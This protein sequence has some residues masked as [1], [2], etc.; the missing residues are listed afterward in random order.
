[1]KIT[2]AVVE[3]ESGPF[4]LTEVALDDPRPDEMIVRMVATGMCHTDLSVRKG[5]TPFPLPAVLGHEGAGVV[6]AVGA[7]VGRF[8]PGDRVIISFASCGVCAGCSSGRPV[9]CGHWT[10]LN[11]LGGSRLDASAPITRPSGPVHGHFFGQSSFASHALVHERSAIKAPDDVDLEVLAPLGCSVQTGVG[12]V[13]NVA[14]PQPGSTLLVF[15]AGGVGLAALM[16]SKLTAAARVIAVDINPSRLELAHELGATHTVNS[17]ETDPFDA[18]LELTGGVGADYAIETTGRPAV[19]ETAIACM[20]SGGTTVVVGAPPLGTTIPV[21]VPNLLGRGIRLVGTNQGD[22]DPSR[23]LPRLIDLHRRGS[24]PFDR[25][26][27]RFPFDRI[28]DA[29]AAAMN[30][31]VIKPV[32]VMPPVSEKGIHP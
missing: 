23:F 30:G 32:L 24:L 17:A 22:S 12:A 10:E 1:M 28:N 5:Q 31:T 27:H 14:R 20:A 6:E 16:G 7:R 25:L 11:L 4:E 2:A 18:V 13:L 9:Y 21:D 29:A 8:S 3:T 15:G 26:I 19:L